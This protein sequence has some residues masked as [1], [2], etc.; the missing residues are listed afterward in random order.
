MSHD[1]FQNI[2]KHID[3]NALNFEKGIAFTQNPCEVPGIGHDVDD[4]VIA[5]DLQGTITLLCKRP[6]CHDIIKVVT[7]DDLP[8]DK[9]DELQIILT[10]VADIMFDDDDD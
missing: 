8:R 10:G 5:Y 6:W 2:V 1:D 4:P 9:Y 3:L 7:V